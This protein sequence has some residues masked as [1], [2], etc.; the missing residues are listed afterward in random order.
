MNAGEPPFGSGGSSPMLPPPPQMYPGAGAPLAHPGP[1]FGVSI[2]QA[3]RGPILLIAIG[4]L[5]AMDHM[6][7]IAFSRT[8]P[9]LLI[10]IG[11]LKL[12]ERGVQR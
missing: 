5:F 3:V 7:S 6:G 1:G 8:W 2:F 11:L 9:A 12:L 10:I 4:T